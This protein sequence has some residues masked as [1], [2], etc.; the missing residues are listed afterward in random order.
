M[1]GVGMRTTG[2][3]IAVRRVRRRLSVG[4][5]LLVVFACCIATVAALVGIA[6]ANSFSRERAR[7]SSDL[8]SAAKSIANDLSVSLGASL[9]T[10]LSGLAK[11]PGLA[12]FDP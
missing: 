5:Y 3:R 9:D 2:G 7:T 6:G 11:S 8:H 12:T 1:I 10:T 4:A